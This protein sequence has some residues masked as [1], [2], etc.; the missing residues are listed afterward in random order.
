MGKPTFQVTP[1]EHSGTSLIEHN[2]VRV[3]FRNGILAHRTEKKN[4]TTKNRTMCDWPLSNESY[5]PW[6]TPIHSLPI[7][8]WL[9][10]GIIK[11][12]LTFKSFL[13]NVT[14]KILIQFPPC[15]YH[16]SLKAWMISYFIHSAIN[17]FNWKF[18]GEHDW[19]NEAK[20]TCRLRVNATFVWMIENI[21]SETV[22]KLE[23]SNKRHDS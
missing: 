22:I 13:S 9:N 11:A 17:W 8:Y 6:S 21:A 12:D 18:I 16:L 5:Q 20:G 10:N 4:K 15:S 7:N 19:I 2:L 23:F 14:T 3:F 1:T